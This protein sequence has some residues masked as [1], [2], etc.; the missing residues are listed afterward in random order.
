MASSTEFS[1]LNVECP[2]CNESY[3]DNP[4]IAFLH[5]DCNHYVCTQCITSLASLSPPST[6]TLVEVVKCPLSGCR[7]GIF[8]KNITKAE[9]LVKRGE[10]IDLV[11]TFSDNE[12]TKASGIMD[13]DVKPAAVKSE[14]N[15][16]KPKARWQTRKVVE[17]IEVVSPSLVKKRIKKEIKAEMKTEEE[18]ESTDDEKVGREESTAYKKVKMEESIDDGWF[19]GGESPAKRWGYKMYRQQATTINILDSKSKVNSNLKRIT[20]VVIWIQKGKTQHSAYLLEDWDD[21]TDNEMLWVEWASNGKKELIHKHQ[22]VNADG[23][24][25]RK[26][27]KPNYFHKE[28]AAVSSRN[29]SQLNGKKKKKKVKKAP[30]NSAPAQKYEVG[31]KVAGEFKNDENKDK[32]FHGEIVSFNTKK[33]WYRVVYEDGDMQDYEE[34]EITEMLGRYLIRE[35]QVNF[36]Q[37]LVGLFGRRG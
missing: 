28:E 10:V 2:N 29:T 4:Q 23:L 24:Q 27:R 17:N 15:Y 30:S 22:I 31:T 32:I 9:V 14:A 36:M 13:M 5:G 3:S 7:R 34:Y 21:A 26:R 35:P 37:W 11:D 12:D 20:D 25:A 16:A 8:A 1:P 6:S 18:E 19:W 33:K